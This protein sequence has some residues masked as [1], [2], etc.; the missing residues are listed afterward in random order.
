MVTIKSFNNIVLDMIEHLRLTQPN[1][2]I[3]PNSVARDLFV[4][5]QAL[6]VSG[7]YNVAQQIISIQSIANLNGQDL[8]N[9]AANY[10]ITK[11]TGTKS[12]GTALLTFRSLSTDIS[13]DA[14]AV[15][16]S[17]QNIPFIVISSYVA[18][19]SQTN[20]LRATATRYRQQLNTAGIT[21][22]FALEVSVEAQSFGTAGNISAYSLI[23]HNI[24]EV[25]G[26]TNIS[27]FTGGTGLES[28]SSLRSRVLSVF[29]GANVGTALG[30]RSV[31][32]S[33]ADAIDALVIEPG[34]PL[35]T[36]D[37]TVVVTD[38]SGNK[39]VSE[40]GTGGRV[41]IYVMGENLQNG[42]DSFV[43]NDQSGT[44]D[45]N[46]T[47]N[48]YILGQ[49]DL[50]SDVTLSLNSR[51]VNTLS[52]TDSISNQPVSSISSVSGSISGPNFVEQYSDESG[53]LYGNYVLVKDTGDAGGS[54]FGLDK[55]RWTSNYIALAGESR[56]KGVYNGIDGFAFTDVLK[57]PNISQDLQVT[58]ENSSV[59]SS[60]RQY[61]TTKH[62]PVRT[63]NRVYNLTT[64]E[65]YTIVDQNPDSSDEL[66]TSGRIQI[67]GRTL[68]TSSD[69]LQVDY[70]WVYSFDPNADFDNLNPKDN[71]NKAQ[72]SVDWGHSNYIRDERV[73]TTLDAYN[74]L[75]FVTKYPISR[76]LSVN[77]FET[78]SVVVNSTVSGKS[79]VVPTAVSNVASIRD[80]TISG[81]PEVYDTLSGNGNFS[82][83]VITLPSDTIANGGDSVSVLYN[84]N[85]LLSGI[86]TSLSLNNQVT[87]SPYDIV[88]GGT[89]LSVN[90]V[91]NLI[92][93][94][95][96]TNVSL[97]PVSTDGLNSFIGI[98]GYQPVLN[99]FSGTAIVK[100]V[101]FA[102][103][104]LR[105]T[106]SN[107]PNQGT[108]RIVGTTFNKYTGQYAATVGN[109][110]D[111]STLIRKSE[112]LSSSA[113][114]PSNISVAKVISVEQVQVDVSGKVTAV[115][116][117]FDMTNYSIYNNDW[118]NLALE[119]TSLRK[120]QV[121]LSPTSVNTDNPVTTGMNL[122]VT[123][124][125]TKTNDSEDLFYSRS[126]ALT[127]NKV[128]GHVSSINRISG[129]QDSSGTISGRLLV[130]SF[131]QPIESTSYFVDYNYVAPK[132]NERIT[133]NYEYNKLL[134]DATNSIE[135]SRPIT[136]DVLVKA[137][138][139]ITLDVTASIVVLDSFK[140]REN[141]V[142]Q[143]VAD[144][145]S[146][147]LSASSLGT[148]IDS[149]DVVNNAYNVEG[150]DR[151]TVSKF[152][153][154]GVV[155]TKLS[156][157]A[158]KNE[159][160]APGTISVT[161]EGR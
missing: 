128:F 146:A 97:L 112:G 135:G 63:V 22:E 4:D 138:T 52:G 103:T 120:T 77:T 38:S 85:D 148:T 40:P 99:D 8:V 1:L 84:L 109:T 114:I 58:N 129:F 145:I 43:Y 160:L 86:D 28:D 53:N 122:R 9:F 70:V 91:A 2:D 62:T 134:I 57:I 27:S 80:L 31:I 151:I 79:I 51:R 144:N 107:I 156:I 143:D 113:A 158:Q 105:V 90:Y 35:M 14:G 94:L 131:N 87:L 56:T 78:A 5:N 83:L 7:L 64:G 13:I 25:N 67:S 65:R 16:R 159:Y 88:P 111:M 21:D 47:D 127:T 121:E 12:F 44:G 59:S 106:T 60:S 150:L 68:P 110:L 152:N 48:D 82:N 161:V 133:I 136:A 15:V 123:F 10:G 36:R 140:N 66:N 154:S 139:K 71:L 74:N 41:D 89:T 75:T 46:N 33:L 6:Q 55:F 24:P 153:K 69:V 81:S 118:D 50:T 32:L 11:K 20:A 126:G 76:L 125:Y 117:T 54:P 26:I 73:V 149:S 116:Y 124:Y 96:Q 49:S 42:T 102:P 108:F 95:P 98:D 18:L 157:T 137:A 132:E 115:D 23:S 39:T 147:T 61:V 17:R 130:N 155:G 29:A 104:R 19:A 30:Y 101:R 72:D 45:A 93:I 37:G 100:N 141:T 92:T 142:R 3:K 34:D 119:D